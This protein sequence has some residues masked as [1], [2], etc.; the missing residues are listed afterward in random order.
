MTVTDYKGDRTFG[1]VVDRRF[2]KSYCVHNG[3]CSFCKQDKKIVRYSTRHSICRDCGE[4]RRDVVLPAVKRHEKREA[5]LRQLREDEAA[6][7]A[8]DAER[9]RKPRPQ[10]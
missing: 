2:S 8:D 9:A 5:L 1:D 4:A 7:K 6:A 10:V 3:T